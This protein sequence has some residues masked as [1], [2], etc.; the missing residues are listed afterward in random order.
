MMTRILR[1]ICEQRGAEHGQVIV[2]MA[3]GMVAFCGMVGMAVDVGQLVA[4]K[5]RLQRTADAAA[6]AAA[7]DLPDTSK[8]TS[9][10]MNYV[11]LNQSGTTAALQF[12]QT[13]GPNDTLKVTVKRDVS[14]TFL[15]LLGFDKQEVSASA[16]VRVSG[17]NGGKGL[18]PWGLI[19]S[20]N[21]NSK[22]LQNSCY[23]GNDA[24]GQPKF[25]QNTTCTLKYGAGTNSGG[26]FG[27]VVL[28]GSGGSNYRNDV[29]SGS[30]LWFKKGD[31]IDAQTGNMVGPTGQGISD[32]FAQ[33]APSG[34][35]GNSASDVLKTNS[36]GSVTVKPGCEASPR[37]IVIPVVDQINNPQKSTILGFA[38]FY[39]SG[40]SSSSS[41]G[42]QAQV[43]GQFV[44]FVTELPNSYYTG[45]TG[46]N[47]TAAKLVE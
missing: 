9:A 47:S 14:F 10:A 40:Q 38:F 5:T 17:Y 19:A 43:S 29:A 46:N 27:A 18:V 16:K 2:L 8:A 1:R 23:L 41:G 13:N 24:S 11:G 36:D 6:L 34:C 39:L 26:D 30:N 31:K 3:L 25:K 20:N 45:T 4:M 32:R 15:R 22:L 37:I 7:V 12:L 33:P 28:D 21:S 44:K 42:G 35:S